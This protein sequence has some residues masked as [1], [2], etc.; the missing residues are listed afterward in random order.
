LWQ[1]SRISARN[2]VFILLDLKRDMR[3]N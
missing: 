3:E 2:A 1:R